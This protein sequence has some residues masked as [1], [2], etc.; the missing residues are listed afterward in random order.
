MRLAADLPVFLWEHAIAHVAYVRNRAYSLA[1]KTATPYE[2]WYGHKPDVAHLHEFGAPVWILLQGQKVLPK[3]EAKSKRHAL[4]GYDD[5]SKSVK[6]YTAETRSVLTSRNFCFLEPSDPS[7]TIP[8]HLSI[9]LDNVLREWESM[10]DAR[11]TVD[12]WTVDAEPRL[13]SPQKRPAEDETKG[14][15]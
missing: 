1:L 4:I 15:S 14:S 12:A 10:G 5:G 7:D 6:Y 13:L 9:A 2:H 11:N 8:E 3:M